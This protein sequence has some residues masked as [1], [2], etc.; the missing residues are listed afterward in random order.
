MQRPERENIRTAVREV[1]RREACVVRES[2]KQG[3]A[4][5]VPETRSAQLV[6]RERAVGPQ[7]R[8]KVRATLITGTT[9]GCLIAIKASDRPS[10]RARRKALAGEVVR[11]S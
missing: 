9:S 1:H 11:C 2:I 3:R 10:S 6:L 8:R 5:R 7:R 4:A